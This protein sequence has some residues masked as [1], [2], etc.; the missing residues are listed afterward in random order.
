MFFIISFVIGGVFMN[1]Y[2]MASDT[3]LMCLCVDKE[4]SRGSAKSC[5]PSLLEFENNYMWF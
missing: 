5:P 3:L 4:L 1:I 2:G